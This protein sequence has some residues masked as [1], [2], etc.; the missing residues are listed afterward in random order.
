ME[1]TFTTKNLHS[2]N[3]SPFLA[4][5]PFI[6]SLH[7]SCRGYRKLAKV[8]T[9]ASPAPSLPS[10]P[11]LSISI[12]TFPPFP[13]SSSMASPPSQGVCS[14]AAYQHFQQLAGFPPARGWCSTVAL[15]PGN[16]GPAG[17]AQQLA[18]RDG[19]C[20][21]GS[22]LCDLLAEL[23]GLDRESA[24]S[25]WYGTPPLFFLWDKCVAFS[26]FLVFLDEEGSLT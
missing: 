14:T 9:Q 25:A 19:S 24:R 1:K 3:D 21:V 2:R 11:Q 16:N 7:P 4:P 18:P 15:L 5:L 12:T 17:A 8:L 10:F 6:H 22:P 26:L 20:P 13:S 23:K